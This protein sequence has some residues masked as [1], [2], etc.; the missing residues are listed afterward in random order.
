MENEKK[1]RRDLYGEVLVLRTAAWHELGVWYE[2]DMRTWRE[3]LSLYI[4]ALRRSET[5]PK[6][7]GKRA[8]ERVCAWADTV[9]IP[10]SLYAQ[11]EKLVPFYEELGFVLTVRMNPHQRL[12]LWRDPR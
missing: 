4:G 11:C 1:V 7:N 8:M 2:P 12:D 5:A 3:P 9:K 6:G 10:I